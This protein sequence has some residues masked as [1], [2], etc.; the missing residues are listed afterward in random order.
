MKGIFLAFSQQDIEEMNQENSLI[1]TFKDNGK[2]KFSADIEDAWDIFPQMFDDIFST[3]IYIEEKELPLN[4]CNLFSTDNVNQATKELSKWTHESVLK[5]FQNIKKED[6]D[7]AWLLK[8]FDKMVVFFQDAHNQGL[9]CV[10][11]V[12]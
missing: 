6:Y 7:E 2:Y 12:E 4:G 11:I 3:G 10:F 5:A 8:Q 1:L 9:G